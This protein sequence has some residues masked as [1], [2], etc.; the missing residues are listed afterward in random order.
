[1]ALTVFIRVSLWN[2]CPVASDRCII[3]KCNGLAVEMCQFGRNRQGS[4]IATEIVFVVSAKGVR[5]FKIA[6]VSLCSTRAI[7]WF[8]W[9]KRLKSRFFHAMSKCHAIYKNVFKLS[10]A[11]YQTNMPVTCIQG[12]SR[13]I[14]TQLCWCLGTWDHSWKQA[15]TAITSNFFIIDYLS[16]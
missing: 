1:M 5:I 2:Q 12:K 10:V 7:G 13:Q 6:L 15:I 11:Q 9:T 16:N 8:L 3:S 4:T 14:Q